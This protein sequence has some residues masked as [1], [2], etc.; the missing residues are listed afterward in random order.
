[1]RQPSIYLP[2]GGGPCFFMDPPEDDPARWIAMADYLSSLPGHLPARPDALLVISAHWECPRPTLLSAPAPGLLFD[3]YGFPPHTYTLTYPAPGAAG[4]I[5]RVRTLLEGAGIASD[6]DPARGYDHGV[7]VPLKVAFPDA[8]IPILQLSLQ[9]GLDP[10]RHIAIGRALE[11]LRDANVAV[12]GSGLSFHNLGGLGDPALNRSATAFDEWL[13]DAVQKPAAERGS[14]LEAWSAAPGARASHPRE[15][16]LLPL[17]VAA[18]AAGDDPG[19][20][21]FSGAIWGKAV[22]AYHFG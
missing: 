6:E 2:H 1:M 20:Q 13:T 19:R 11:P 18:G 16:H 22:S 3:Y 14:A 10:A 5:P 12:I 9:K 8:D 17:M 4:L 7:F 15:E 21:V